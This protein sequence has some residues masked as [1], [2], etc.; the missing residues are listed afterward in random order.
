MNY[1]GIKIPET[2]HSKSYIWFI[3]DSETNAWLAFFS[4]PD[5]DKDR[6]PIKYALSDGIRA[7]EAIGYKCVPLFVCEIEAKPTT[8]AAGDGQ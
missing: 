2:P 5:K 1:Y 3:A 8:D 7:Y 6:Y 4:Q